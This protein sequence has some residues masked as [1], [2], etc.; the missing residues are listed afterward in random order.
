M[1]SLPP[2]GAAAPADWQSQIRGP[3]WPGI[4]PLAGLKPVASRTAKGKAIHN[5]LELS[6]GENVSAIVAYNPK[7]VKGSYLLMITKDGI[8]KKTPIEGF[9]N[10]RRTGIIAINLKKGDLLGWVRL[11]GGKDEVVLTTE[12]GQSIR[13]KESQIRSMGRTAAGI[14]GMKLKQGDRIAGCGLLLESAK[15]E[16][17]AAELL[18]VMENG[19]GKRTPLKEYKLQNRGGSGVRTANITSKTGLLINAQVIVDQTEIFAL[20][21]KGQIIRVPLDSVRKTGRS[22]QGVRIMNVKNGDRL[23]AIVV[24]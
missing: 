12:K 24:I 23:A 21:A 8:M 9:G 13:F 16:N 22:A 14:R 6:S 20:S 4:T 7:V 10:I 2:E 11:S 18:V 1:S 3:G 15:T 17:K 19:F 5:F